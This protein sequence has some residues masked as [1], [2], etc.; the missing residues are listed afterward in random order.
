VIK[1]IHLLLRELPVHHS[2]ACRIILMRRPMEEVIASQCA[3]LLR[4]GKE[5]A[6]R[7]IVQKAFESQLA[8]LGPWLASR[9]DIAV[10]AGALSSS[11][12]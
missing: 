7:A 5:A 10:F 9:P 4:D 11:T 2:L 6:D 8:Q 3:M 12:S 1:I